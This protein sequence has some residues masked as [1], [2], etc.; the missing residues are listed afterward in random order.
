MSWYSLVRCEWNQA[1]DGATPD[2]LVAPKHE[3]SVKQVLVVLLVGC[4]DLVVESKGE[5]ECV[6]ATVPLRCGIVLT[7]LI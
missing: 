6:A 2:Y 3:P 1:G 4:S 7:R 5:V